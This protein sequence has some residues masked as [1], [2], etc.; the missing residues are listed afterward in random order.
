[1]A[2][3]NFAS[4]LDDAPTE[5]AKAAVLP[6]G[7]YRC[8]VLGWRKDK[9]SKKGTPFVEFQLRPVAAEEDVDEDQLDEIGGLEGKI[10]YNT[11]YYK[12]ED[13]SSLRFLDRFHEHCGLELEKGVRR[14]MRND[15]VRNAQ[16]LA[17]VKH[18]PSDQ[19]PERINIRISTA[20]VE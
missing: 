15:A 20:P 2:N 13:T 18:E 5:V 9:S 14:T 3:T 7:T 19:D 8:V 1:M 4:I 11:F 12:E 10:L 16:V 6:E 17:T